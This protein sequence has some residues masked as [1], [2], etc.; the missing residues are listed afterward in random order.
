MVSDLVCG[1]SALDR[2]ACRAVLATL[3]K[4]EAYFD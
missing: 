2:P 3:L 4:G 1:G